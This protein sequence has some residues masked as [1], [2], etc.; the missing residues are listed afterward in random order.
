MTLQIDGPQYL[1]A[2]FLQ[3]LTKGMPF[4]KTLED[5]TYFGKYK[6]LKIRSLENDHHLV[7]TIPSIHDEFGFL[8]YIEMQ[9]YY[10]D[11]DEFE[12]Q[13]TFILNVTKPFSFHFNGFDF[14]W[15]EN[16]LSIKKEETLF[17]GYL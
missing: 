9:L 12:V 11:Q 8:L 10:C 2:N 15:D 5:T 6:E 1:K 14:S 17:E 3:E 4:V 7:F 16:C 13:K